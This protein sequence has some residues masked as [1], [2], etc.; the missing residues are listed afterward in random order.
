MQ[1]H[2]KPTDA[3]A[4]Q[5]PG[6]GQGGDARTNPATIA[7]GGMS[8]DA[9]VQKVKAA[10]QGVEGVVTNSVRVGEAKITA[11][12]AG[13]DA[14]CDCI[15]AA[16][17]RPERATSAAKSAA[18]NEGM[19]AGRPTTNGPVAGKPAIDTDADRGHLTSRPESTPR[20]ATP[21]TPDVVVK[22]TPAVAGMK[23][24]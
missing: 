13:C 21:G 23:H 24:S 11:T 16:G 4:Q 15:S 9:C 19:I 20:I 3:T 5:K 18:E 12:E 17:Y 14:A 22:P 7:I 6:A 1:N 8:G 10:L 2:S